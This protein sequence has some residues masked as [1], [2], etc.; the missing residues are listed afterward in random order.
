VTCPI[1]R[2]VIMNE[3]GG[4]RSTVENGGWD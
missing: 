3:H 2:C 4:I 1:C